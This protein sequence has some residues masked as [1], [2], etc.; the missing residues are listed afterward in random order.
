MSKVIRQFVKYRNRKIHEIG[1][2]HPYTTMEALLAI[3]ASGGQIKVIDDETNEDIT[4]FTLARMIYDRSR[5][6]K[7]AYRASELHKLIVTSAAGD[8][9]AA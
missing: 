4:A 2:E 6:D 8:S 7:D 5:T 1:D 3:V 9:K